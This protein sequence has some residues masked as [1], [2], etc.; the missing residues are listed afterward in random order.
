VFC[1]W[2]EYILLNRIYSM[3]FGVLLYFCFIV[4]LLSIILINLLINRGAVLEIV[5]TMCIF[6]QCFVKCKNNLSFI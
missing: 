1:L 5:A 4:I 3:F 2:V 6:S